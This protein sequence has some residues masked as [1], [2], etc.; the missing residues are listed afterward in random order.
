MTRKVKCG[1]TS[2][3]RAHL[4]AKEAACEACR[5]AQ[6][7]SMREWRAAHPGYLQAWRQK[8]LDEWWAVFDEY[9]TLEL[10]E[11]EVS[12]EPGPNPA[13][14][15][16]L[17]LLLRHRPKMTAREVA[18]FVGCTYVAAQMGLSDLREAGK[19]R[20]Q[21]DGLSWRWSLC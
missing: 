2:G 4:R 15:G 17:A 19:A 16:I 12:T 13:P 1:T 21:W 20:R 14:A 5:A 11:L 8:R 18:E 7:A 6:A 9:A 3:Y 10:P